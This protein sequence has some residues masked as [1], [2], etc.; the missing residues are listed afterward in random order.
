MDRKVAG[1]RLGDQISILLRNKG[2]LFATAFG[3]G[4][5]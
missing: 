5:G 4:T 3:P 2:L 1:Y